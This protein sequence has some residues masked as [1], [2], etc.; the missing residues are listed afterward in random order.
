MCIKVVEKNLVMLKFVFDYF[1][2]PEMCNKA[3]LEEPGLID[4]I[5]DRLKTQE[6]CENIF[7]NILFN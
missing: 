2:S 3:I 7:L 6:M 1:M 5:P 4:F